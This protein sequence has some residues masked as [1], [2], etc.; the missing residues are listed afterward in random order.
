MLN[1]GDV[2]TLKTG[3]PK[4]VIGKIYWFKTLAECHW[5]QEDE[6]KWTSGGTLVESNPNH[7]F[8][9]RDFPVSTL[10]LST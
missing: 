4:M 5:W 2:V 1:K 3:G 9:D 10:I 8:L 7:R 6:S